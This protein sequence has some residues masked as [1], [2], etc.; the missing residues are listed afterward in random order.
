VD[1]LSPPERVLL[2]VED[3]PDSR[4]SLAML[5]EACGYPTAEAADGRQALDYL[6]CHP[7]PGLI[8]LDLTMPVMDGWQ[9]RAAQ[10]ADPA[11]NAIPTAVTSA[12]HTAAATPDL[13][14]VAGFYIKPVD[15][16]ELLETIRLFCGPAA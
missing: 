10:R 1:P 16:D 4:K 5:L 13:A 11:L 9:F 7:P 8:L 12:Y 14:D 6:H 2:I 3:H 15:P